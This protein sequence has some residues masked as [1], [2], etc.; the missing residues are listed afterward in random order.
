MA[1]TATHWAFRV[2]RQTAFPAS[3][4]ATSTATRSTSAIT[5]TEHAATAFTTRRASTAKSASRASTATRWLRRRATA[6]VSLSC[7]LKADSLQKKRYIASRKNL[8]Y[9]KKNSPFPRLIFVRKS[10]IRRTVRCCLLVSCFPSACSCHINGTDTPI[11]SPSNNVVL[12]CDMQTGQCP[13]RANVTGRQCDRCRDGHWN[14]ASRQGC[15][16]CAC[17]SIGSK[18]TLCDVITG[19]CSCQPGVL[20]PKCDACQPYHYG[21]SAEGCKR[22]RAT[23]IN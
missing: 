9:F 1:T 4:T 14:L 13:C 19:V 15:E 7:W 10:S 20:E 12:E 18:D 21:F 11:G 17:N 3:V 6:S 23:R 8:H 2:Y 22:K 16:A 5:R